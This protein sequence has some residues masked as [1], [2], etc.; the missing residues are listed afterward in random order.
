MASYIFNTFFNLSIIES[1]YKSSN[2]TGVEGNE[3]EFVPKYNFKT[4]L[5][6]GYKNFTSYM[7]YSYLSDQFSDSTNAINS[8]LSGV[9]GIIPSYEILDFSISYSF[10]RIRLESGIN[11]MLN[12]HYTLSE[13]STIC[14]LFIKR[15]FD[16][17]NIQYVLNEFIPNLDYNCK[18]IYFVPLRTDY[19]KIL[20]IIP[21]DNNFNVSKSK[22]IQSI[23][24]DTKCFRIMKTMKPDVYELYL[25]NDNNIIK[26]GIALVQT[27]Q[28]SHQLLS[29][30]ENK[31][32][33]DE[34][35]VECKFNSDFNKWE[36]LSLSDGPIDKIE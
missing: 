9:I 11:N 20:Y 17:K 10:K 15:Y 2:E 21:K 7:Q 18:G 22:E 12:N 5:K 33:Q 23:S 25:N 32:Y 26:Q 14:P 13:F 1:K 4:G 34:I 31:D 30:F 16:Y 19:S 3:V 27:I 28:L 36:P 35:L 29:Y 6:F 24:K 8:N